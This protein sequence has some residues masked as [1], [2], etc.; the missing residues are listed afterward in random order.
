MLRGVKI[1][2]ATIAHS[3]VYLLICMMPW[4]SACAGEME[5]KSPPLMIPVNL[6]STSEMIEVAINVSERYTYTFGFSFMFNR[7]VPNDSK[8]VLELIGDSSRKADTGRYVNTGVPM[9]VRLKVDSIETDN[10]G[11]HYDKTVSE[12]PKYAG[13]GYK[14]DGYDK[15]IDNI[16]LEPGIY[17]VTLHNLRPGMEFLNTSVFFHIRKAYFGK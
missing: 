16:L 3:N 10:N 8:R 6:S 2:L 1:G 7:S 12:I 11:I 9:M 15:R 5:I 17:F 4:L 14:H 13:P